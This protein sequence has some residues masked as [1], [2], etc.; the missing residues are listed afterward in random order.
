MT[1]IR[2]LIAVFLAGALASSARAHD[3]GL[4]SANLTRTPDG[5]TVMLT[6]DWS[7]LG[8]LRAAATET[9]IASIE[10]QPPV[11]FGPEWGAIA[12]GFLKVAAGDQKLAPVVPS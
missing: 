5:L 10:S 12:A 4:S 6:F 9:D 2:S 11:A 1:L 8:L 3:P 7:D